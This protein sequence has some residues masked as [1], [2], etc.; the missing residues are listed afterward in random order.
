MPRKRGFTL[1]ELLVV[2]AIIAVLIALLLPAVQS[3]REAARRT[4]CRNNLKQMALAGHNYHDVNR[5]FPAGISVVI[6]PVLEPLFPAVCCKCI[7]PVDD[8]NVHVWAE[9][10]LPFMEASRVYSEICMN[11]PIFAP[12]NLGVLHLPKYCQKNAGECGSVCSPGLSAQ[13]RP[14]FPVTSALLRRDRRIRFWRRGVLTAF[15]SPSYLVPSPSIGVVPATTPP[16]IGTPAVCPS[17]TP[18]S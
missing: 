12:V 13:R 10:L 6:G 4:Q 17:T 8:P 14:S 5:A 11:G 7:Q 15:C 18:A 9:K 1:I 2:I 16:S 3:A